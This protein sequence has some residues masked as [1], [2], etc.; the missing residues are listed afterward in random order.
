MWATSVLVKKW[1]GSCAGHL[2]GVI[3]VK[4]EFL[5]SIFINYRLA[6]KINLPVSAGGDGKF[7]MR[8]LIG[9]QGLSLSQ[10]KIF[11]FIGGHRARPI[12]T[13]GLGATQAA[14]QGGG[15]YIF[16]PFRDSF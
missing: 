13:L 14:Q 15:V 11:H 4:Q 16:H 7:I 12:I 9:R 6:I 1:M 3:D 8:F 2:C 10:T 5:S